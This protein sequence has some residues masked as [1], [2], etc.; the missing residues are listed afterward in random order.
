LLPSSSCRPS[1]W[2]GRLRRPRR[3]AARRHATFSAAKTLFLSGVGATGAAARA[4]GA[5][6]TRC[7]G[8][9]PTWSCRWRAA[10]CGRRPRR[11]H[12]LHA[13][14]EA[15]GRQLRGQVPVAEGA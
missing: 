8:G 12:H 1:S 15:V 3:P 13:I 11:A 6:L 2:G 9:T 10:P 14:G 5:A 7:C 4:A